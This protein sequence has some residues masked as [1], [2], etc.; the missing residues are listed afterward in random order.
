MLWNME[1]I[2]YC[3]RFLRHNARL[4]SLF[5]PILVEESFTLTPYCNRVRLQAVAPSR[6][7]ATPQIRATGRNRGGG[8]FGVRSH[9]VATG[10]RT[11]LERKQHGV[12]VAS[13]VHASIT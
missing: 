1:E 9:P 6:K 8:Y 10:C 11:R 13:S 5:R 2:R 4:L 3:V 7:E 12:A